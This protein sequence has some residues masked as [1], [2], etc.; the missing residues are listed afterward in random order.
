MNDKINVVLTDAHLPVLDG[1][2]YRL[3]GHLDIEVVG[4][5]LSGTELFPL[6][7]RD[8]SILLLDLNLPKTAQDNS[9]LPIYAVVQR[10]IRKHKDV[11][12]VGI[13]GCDNP[14]VLRAAFQC[15]VT[16]VVCKT[17]RS[18]FENLASN[19]RKVADNKS[20]TSRAV[21]ASMGMPDDP[22]TDMSAS[23]L[24][25]LQLRYAYPNATISELAQMHTRAESTFRNL[26]SRSYCKLGV[27]NALAAVLR[28]QELGL[29]GQTTNQ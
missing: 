2:A 22:F 10:L 16:N 20:V 21:L 25:A 19:L 3:R 7:E 6:L 15:G 28:A 23:E 1:Y 18:F 5:A 9:V 4:N 13:A 17:E 29:F 11:A 8:V 27:D 24:A 14:N 12:I 26:L